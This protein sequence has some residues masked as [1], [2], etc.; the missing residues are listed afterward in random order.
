M[1]NSKLSR[2]LSAD[3]EL[4]DGHGRAYPQLTCQ[5][6]G[7]QRLGISALPRHLSYDRSMASFRSI[8]G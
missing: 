8:L 7:R 5:C 2:Q 6:Q 1:N 3:V 4:K